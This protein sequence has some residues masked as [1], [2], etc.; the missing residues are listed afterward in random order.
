MTYSPT[1]G[2]YSSYPLRYAQ[3]QP[4]H[5]HQHQRQNSASQHPSAQSYSRH[6]PPTHDP[7]PSYAHNPHLRHPQVPIKLEESPDLP[8]V[9]A[10]SNY[11]H[12][13]NPS[14]APTSAG[15]SANHIPS[16]FR[17]GASDFSASA[18]PTSSSPT[19]FTFMSH[20]PWPSSSAPGSSSYGA[21]SQY[22]TAGIDRYTIPSP[23]SPANGSGHHHPLALT[24]DYDDDGGD[25]LGDLPSG[26]LG[27]MG[28]ASY[29]GSVGG[30]SAAEKQVRRRSSK[31]CDQCRKSKCKCERT[32]PQDPCRNCV[33]LGTR[34]FSSS[35]AS[36]HLPRWLP[37]LVLLVVF[38]RLD[39]LRRARAQGFFPP[40]SLGG[41]SRKVCVCACARAQLSPS[42]RAHPLFLS[43]CVCVDDAMSE[44]IASFSSFAECT[45]LG[46][47]RKRGPPKGYIDA[48]EARLHQTEAL[49]GILLSSKDSRAKSMLEDLAEVST[50]PLPL[51]PFLCSGPQ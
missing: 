12:H 6:T 31:A 40:L 25:D 24:D 28:L 41:A 13:V 16:L 17:F 9:S 20:Q 4:H 29:G 42:P 46:P 47:S 43:G 36:S 38:F 10:L 14:S 48:I 7:K 30:K 19:A 26:G 22:A 33:M 11:D 32:N 51:S 21:Q 8:P 1:H 34:K 50:S 49:I 39:W 18:S 35:L 44:L 5:L 15:S 27:G 2:S 3:Q 45:F 23:V 37:F